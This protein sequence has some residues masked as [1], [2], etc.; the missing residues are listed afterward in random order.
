MHTGERAAAYE[1]AR[2]SLS[3]GQMM[4]DRRVEF[5]LTRADLAERADMTLPQL[6]RRESGRCYTYRA[7]WT[8]G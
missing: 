5:G 6:S 4:H 8:V 3:L 1:E 7:A 2:A